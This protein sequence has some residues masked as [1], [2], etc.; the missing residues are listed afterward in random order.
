MYYLALNEPDEGDEEMRDCEKQRG[1][2]EEW[3]QLGSKSFLGEVE[4]IEV[5]EEEA[6]MASIPLGESSTPEGQSCELG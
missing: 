2:V 5:E 4:S 3:T 6:T 1:K